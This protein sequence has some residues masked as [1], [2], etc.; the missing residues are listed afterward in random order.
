MCNLFSLKGFLQLQNLSSLYFTLVLDMELGRRRANS[1]PRW[2]QCVYHL[3][4]KFQCHSFIFILFSKGRTGLIILRLV[5][6]MLSASRTGNRTKN[7]WNLDNR[8]FDF[9]TFDF[10]NTGVENQWQVFLG[11]SSGFGGTRIER[12]PQDWVRLPNF[13]L[14][15]IV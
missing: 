8:T 14:S 7:S 1:F 4:P 6:A 5:C 9:Q 11:S 3:Q 2:V 15:N 13:K 12:N 10:C